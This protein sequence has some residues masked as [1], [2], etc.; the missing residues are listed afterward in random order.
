M[1]AWIS[2][3]IVAGA[4]AGQQELQ[5]EGRHVRA[6]LDPVQQVLAK[7]LPSKVAFSF[8]SSS[9]RLHGSHTV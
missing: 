1:P 8:W 6:L 5:H 4:V 3:G 2:A 9:S 7:T